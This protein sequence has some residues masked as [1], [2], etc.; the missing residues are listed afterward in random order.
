MQRKI[1][2]VIFLIWSYILRVWSN[3]YLYVDITHVSLLMLTLAPRQNNCLIG[4]SLN[5]LGRL[6]ALPWPEDSKGL[7]DSRVTLV[8]YMALKSIPS[9]NA[10]SELQRSLWPK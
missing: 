8:G 4:T 7:T 2:A 10:L 9:S 3:A 6:S 5:R 1:I